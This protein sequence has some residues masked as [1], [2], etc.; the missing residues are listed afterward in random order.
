MS[1]ATDRLQAEQSFHDRQAVHRSA[2][3][4]QRPSALHI[5]VDSY[6]DH[7]T[8][9]RPAF[10]PLGD[11][12]G[13]EVLD[14]GCG[15]GMASVVLARL[16]ARVTAFDL[17]PRYLREAR[18]RAGANDVAIDWV[19]ADGARLPFADESFDRVWGNAILH[20]LDLQRAGRELRRVMRPEGIAVFCEPWGENPFV[21]FARRRLHYPGKERT[22]DELPLRR[23]DLAVLRAVFPQLDARGFQLLSMVRRV[24]RTGWLVRR[25]DRCDERLLTSVPFL[26]QFCRYMVLT[27]RR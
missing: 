25:L 5:D 26:Q 2:T 1:L 15:H 13:L 4:E 11:V 3:F 27:L 20:H 22:P 17:S 10:A 8:W 16:G 18:C 12:H 21:N 7:E 23:R 14:Y 24:L 6:L 19:Q 9:I